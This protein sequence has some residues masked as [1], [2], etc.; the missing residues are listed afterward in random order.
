VKN[1]CDRV[2][3]MYCGRIVEEGSARDIFSHPSHEYTRSLLACADL[4]TTRE[5][6]P[7]IPGRVPAV[8]EGWPSGC[9]FHPRCEKARPECRP[10]GGFPE[11]RGTAPS[12]GVVASGERPHLTHCVLY[13]D[14]L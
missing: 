7:V 4:R 8:E 3:V 12:S 10:L 11:R 13:G 5:T 2:L 1:F 14:A 9:P 6:L